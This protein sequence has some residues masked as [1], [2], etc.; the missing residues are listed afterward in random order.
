M[1]K[2][3]AFHMSVT[4]AIAVAALDLYRIRSAYSISAC[5]YSALFILQSTGVTLRERE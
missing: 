3:G 4:F 5:V 2:W 1:G